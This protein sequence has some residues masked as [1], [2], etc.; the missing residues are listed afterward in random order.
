MTVQSDNPKLRLRYVFLDH[1]CTFGHSLF[2]WYRTVHLDGSKI[3]Y[4]HRPNGWHFPVNLDKR[5]F[6][7]SKITLI[8][9]NYGLSKITV[10]NVILDC[11]KSWLW[12]VIFYRPQQ[13]FW[14]VILDRPK[15]GLLT[16]ILDR[17]FCCCCCSIVQTIDIYP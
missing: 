3:M 8:G 4:M 12:T 17:P 11:P 13:Q 14:T 5:L 16:V 6:R 15:L 7:Q 9:R 1:I 2:V 10:G